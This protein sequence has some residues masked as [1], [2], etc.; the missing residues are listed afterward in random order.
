MQLAEQLS[1]IES[2]LNAQTR[3]S[4]EVRSLRSKCDLV[5]AEV[6]HA[7][8]S[9]LLCLSPSQCISLNRFLED[10]QALAVFLDSSGLRPEDDPGL[11]R[12]E[13]QTEGH[14]AQAT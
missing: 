6:T 8:R 2:I 11:Y 3:L 1:Q 14:S 5:I 13:E 10:I 9:E 7:L 12:Q 4:W